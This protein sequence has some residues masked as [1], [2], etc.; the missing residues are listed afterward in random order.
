MGRSFLER[1]SYIRGRAPNLNRLNRARKHLALSP[2]QYS[3]NSQ[4]CVCSIGCSANYGRAIRR[5]Y[6]RGRA[7]NLNRL[8]RAR[9]IE[10][11]SPS[12]QFSVRA[13]LSRVYVQL[14]ARP[15]KKGCEKVIYSWEASNLN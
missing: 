10:K 2:I 5:S 13:V 9:K 12:T 1:R 15:I 3:R 6:I 14:N 11:T 4:S 7:P 8:S